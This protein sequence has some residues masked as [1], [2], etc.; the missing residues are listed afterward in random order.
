MNFIILL[1]SI[2]FILSSIKFILSSTKFIL[3]SI[4]SI[5]VEIINCRFVFVVAVQIFRIF[6]IVRTF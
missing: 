1:S 4:N 5:N 6:R 3:S 2:K